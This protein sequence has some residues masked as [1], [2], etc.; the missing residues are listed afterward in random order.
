[1]LSSPTPFAWVHKRDG[2]LVPFD[3]AKI[4]QSLFAA[5]ESLGTPDA[6]LA[7]ELTD[8][9]LHFLAQAADSTIPTTGL[10]SEMVEK[11]VRELGAPKLAQAYTNHA[12][13]RTRTKR[14]TEEPLQPAAADSA[15]VAFVDHGITG[16]IEPQ[17]L[18][19]RTAAA[20]LRQYSLER[21]FTRD[22]VSAHQSGLLVLGDLQAPG[23]LAACV[24]GPFG[25][26]KRGVLEGIQEA[27]GLAGSFVAI[28]APE[29]VLAPLRPAAVPSYVRELDFGLRAAGLRA[30]VNLNLATPPAWAADRAVGPLFS[31]QQSTLEP[32]LLATQ[33]ENVLDQLLARGP[34]LGDKGKTSVLR[35]DWHLS[36]RDFR[37]EAAGRLSRLARR[38][39]ERSAL[40]FVFDRGRKGVSLGEGLDRRQGSVVM[41]IG[42]NLPQ[43]AEQSGRRGDPAT[44]FPKL[45]SLARLA[46]T[47]GLQKREFLRRQTIERP[48]L[49]AGF[50][51]E[52]ARLVVVPIGLDRTVGDLRREGMCTPGGL[53]LARHIVGH[54]REVLYEE[55]R[56]AQ[57]E[58]CLDSVHSFCMDE[59]VDVQPPPME[60]AAG[61]TPWD[62]SATVSDQL[63]AAGELHA[64]IA[65]GTTA[66]FLPDRSVHADEITSWLRLAWE[67]T[68]V[69]R[70]CFVRP[71][72]SQRQLAV[73]WQER[74]P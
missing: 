70:L 66:I 29:Y 61:L 38:A 62:E 63:R 8:G 44:V 9:V 6:F 31:D 33:A 20:C 14:A 26:G 37:P 54:L 50:V 39:L 67:K 32:E 18:A 19:R 13:L 58:T 25:D 42:L 5:T 43:L 24:L 4:S 52:R 51:L 45:G 57:L 21:V 41:T 2:R 69:N 73:P 56:A 7:R 40:A 74:S 15:A 64:G 17:S 10:V 48:E 68:A 53:E 65:A 16:R 55:G 46:L 23:E 60:R 59:E 35:V 28:D 72:L 11:V 71:R 49:N 1:M 12:Q 34:R 30:V 27:R 47:G 36:E 22:L 3:S